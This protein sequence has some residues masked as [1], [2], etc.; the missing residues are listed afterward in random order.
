MFCAICTDEI[1]GKVFREPL[2]KND[3]LV[4]VCSDCATEKPIA[5][6]ASLAYEPPPKSTETVK[7]AIARGTRH[8]LGNSAS[9]L[10]YKERVDDS[11]RRHDKP[12]PGFILVR[13]RKPPGFTR[14]N[15]PRLV[16]HE[17]WAAE[18]RYMGTTNRYVLFDRPD[19]DGAR[20]ARGE[21]KT[22]P[23][24]ALEQFREVTN[25]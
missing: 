13:I 5:R 4:A 2:G 25:G 7:R 14:E 16:A 22:N 9:G 15:A 18:A 10:P 20:A 17:P 21:Q 12:R 19:V 3:A 8:V 1:V 6:E 23:L 11:V 24:D